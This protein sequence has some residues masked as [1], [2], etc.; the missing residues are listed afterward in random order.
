VKPPTTGRRESFSILREK[1]ARMFA[2]PLDSVRCE[3][4][5]DGDVEVWA[6][7]VGAVWT[8]GAKPY[9]STLRDAAVSFGRR[10][11]T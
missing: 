5:E 8:M 7:G 3:E 1:Y 9:E 10:P 6:P 2:I 4:R 11:R